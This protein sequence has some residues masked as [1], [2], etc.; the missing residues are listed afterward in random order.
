MKFDTT[1]ASASPSSYATSYVP[2]SF[3]QEILPGY[4]EAPPRKRAVT[5]VPT[6][7]R[8]VASIALDVGSDVGRGV[9]T[10]V[11][12]GVGAGVAPGVGPS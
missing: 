5:G 9:G 8:G 4:M 12:P 2:S 10:G 11:G 6:A 7:R 1:A 3:T